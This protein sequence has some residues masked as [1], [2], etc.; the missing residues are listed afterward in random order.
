MLLSFYCRIDD[1]SFN[2]GLYTIV[3][4]DLWGKILINF[5]ASFIQLFKRGSLE[6]IATPTSI[7]QLDVT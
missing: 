3:E 1:N 4:E 5:A 7:A 2:V 6:K